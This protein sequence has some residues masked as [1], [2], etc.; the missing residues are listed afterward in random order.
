MNQNH[1][2]THQREQVYTRVIAIGETASKEVVRIQETLVLSRY[3]LPTE[4]AVADYLAEKAVSVS[5]KALLILPG[6]EERLDLTPLERALLALVPPIRNDLA[7]K[8]PNCIQFVRENTPARNR[9]VDEPTP[10]FLRGEMGYIP[11]D[12]AFNEDDDVRNVASTVLRNR[13]LLEQGVGLKGF[14]TVA[15]GSD[16]YLLPDAREMDVLLKHRVQN[17]ATLAVKGALSVDSLDAAMGLIYSLSAAPDSFSSFPDESQN[18]L[19]EY[20]TPAVAGLLKL[21]EQMKAQQQRPVVDPRSVLQGL[22]LLKR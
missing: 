2:Y 18:V 7:Q 19:E 8:A 10:Y 4:D 1:G 21:S 11:D 3:A 15:L 6:Q 22:D 12:F 17:S 16:S 14:F 20:C 5:T 13:G 9:G